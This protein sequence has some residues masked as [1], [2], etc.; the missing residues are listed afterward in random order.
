VLAA[1]AVGGYLIGHNALVGR[2]HTPAIRSAIA[3]NVVVEYP[4][5]WQRAA[6]PAVLGLPLAEASVFAPG[7]RGDVSG[8]LVGSLAAGEASPLPRGFL[9]ALSAPPRTAVV[10][11]SEGQAYRYSSVSVSAFVGSITLY[12]VPAPGR[13]AT[14]AACYAR[15]GSEEFLRRCSVVVAGLT[16]I[17]RTQSYDLTPEPAYARHLAAALGEVDLLRR[18]IAWTGARAATPGELRRLGGDLAAR[19]SQAAAAL[20]PLEP[21]PP[22]KAAHALLTRALAT[23]AAAYAALA[24]AE[25]GGGASELLHARARVRAA[26]AA[27][28]E[29]L[30]GFSLLGYGPAPGG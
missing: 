15:R 27:V 5:S 23:A 18:Q 7:G 16:E 12:S 25:S 1:V 17:G 19:F 28:D 29:S 3:A 6:N 21:P 30:E 9:H 2:A 10:N 13:R 20:A 26:E 24:T 14:I 11:L 22:A 8:L 4:R